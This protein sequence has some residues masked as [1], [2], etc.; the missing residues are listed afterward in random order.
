MCR[1]DDWDYSTPVYDIDHRHARKEHRCDECYRTILA[2]EPYDYHHWVSPDGCGHH[3]LCSHCAVLMV[4][5]SR[6]CGGT[7]LGELI[8]DI[9]E[10]ATEYH[11]S[12]LAWL[13]TQARLQW[14]LIDGP[15]PGIQIPALPLP[16]TS[17]PT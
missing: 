16:I 11:R 13:A 14:R 4:W 17:A 2:G 8:E 12:D 5:I 9:E 15:W 6:D 7:I 10:H 3:K 1:V